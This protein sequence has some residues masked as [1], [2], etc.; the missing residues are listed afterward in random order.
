MEDRDVDE[1]STLPVPSTDARDRIFYF[2]DVYNYL[3]YG[4]YP[5]ETSKTA[6]SKTS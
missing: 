2:S 5:E 1:N 3:R 4:K 6:I